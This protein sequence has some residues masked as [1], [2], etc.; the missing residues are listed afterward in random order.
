MRSSDVDILMVPGW[1]NSGHDHWQSRWQRNLKTA[2]RIEQDDWLKP[3]RDAWVGRILADA[4]GTSRPVVLVAHSLGV[5]AVAHA[6]SR[7]PKGL[8]AGAFLVAPAD[9]DNAASWP[10]TEGEVFDVAESGFAPLPLEALPFPS[11]LIA[12][13]NDPYCALERARE[14]AGSWGSAFIEAGNL[15]HINAA[16]GHGPWPEGVL[17]FGGFLQRLTR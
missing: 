16:S 2:R 11:V 4:A 14:L 9:V 12:S 13:S 7:M 10:V 15:G 3:R 8:V 6:G 5:A 17:R 1:S